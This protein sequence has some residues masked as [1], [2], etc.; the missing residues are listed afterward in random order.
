MSLSATDPDAETSSRRRGPLPDLLPQNERAQRASQHGA[1]RREAAQ[2]MELR[3]VANQLKV[4]GDEFNAAVL[5]RAVSRG[6]L[7]LEPPRG[8]FLPPSIFKCLYFS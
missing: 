8:S 1:L 3:R 5:R 6:D 7:T 2:E 4:I